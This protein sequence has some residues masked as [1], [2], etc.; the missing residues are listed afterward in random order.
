MQ[1]S[2]IPQLHVA[3]FVAAEMLFAAELVAYVLYQIVRM[4]LVELLQGASQQR[5]GCM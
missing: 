3:Q 4:R 5:V 1:S 2:F